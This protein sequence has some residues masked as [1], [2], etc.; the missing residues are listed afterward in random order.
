[1]YADRQIE[2]VFLRLFET[3]LNSASPPQSI[4]IFSRGDQ[5][6]IVICV[7]HED[8]AIMAEATAKNPAAAEEDMGERSLAIIREILSLTDITLEKTGE[9]GKSVCY[10]IVI[11]AVSYRYSSRIED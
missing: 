2:R 10:E 3:A 9:P 5:D 7:E 4:R 8:A 11:P 1:V 6:R